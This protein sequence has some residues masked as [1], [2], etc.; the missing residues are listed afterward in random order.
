MMLPSTF[1]DGSSMAWNETMVEDIRGGYIRATPA[2]IAS[3]Q[4][5]TATNSNNNNNNN[6]NNINPV[7]LTS[8]MSQQPTSTAIYSRPPA[9]MVFQTPSINTHISATSTMSTGHSYNHSRSV[10]NNQNN[11]NLN[12]NNNNNNPSWSRLKKR[13]D[14]L[15]GHSN[16]KN[17][18]RRQVFQKNQRETLATK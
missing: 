2:L 9:L 1:D 5:Q 4:I 13:F 3:T 15:P 6:N 7:T 11:N 18:M 17:D 16:M 8:N 10:A 14:K 12:S